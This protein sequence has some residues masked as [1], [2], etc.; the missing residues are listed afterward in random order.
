MTNDKIK[1]I[2]LYAVYARNSGQKR[3]P[4]YIFPFRMSAGNTEKYVKSYQENKELLDFWKN[5]KA[6][7]DKFITDGKPLM[8]QVDDAGDYRF[9]R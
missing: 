3:I 4:V 7:Y 1:E 9:G 2:Y 5:L 8:V 6:G